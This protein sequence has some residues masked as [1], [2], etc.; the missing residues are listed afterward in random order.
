MTKFFRSLPLTLIGAAALTL[1]LANPAQAV[2]FS[3]IGDAPETVAGAQATGSIVESLTAISGTVVGATGNADIFRIFLS[4]GTLFSATTATAGTPV[5]FDTQLFL[6]TAAGVGL[7][8]N[9]DG[10]GAQ[11]P[12]ST[13]N[14]TPTV[15]GE[16]LLAISGFDYDP[17]AGSTNIFPGGAALP[18][19]S[20]PLTNWQLFPGDTEADAGAYTI[21]LTGAQTVPEPSSVLGLMALAGLGGGAMLQRKRKAKVNA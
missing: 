6:F 14:F 9:D 15:S 11:F 8:S 19:T 5:N 16:Y 12:R 20:S 18:F 3:E 1:S 2:T 7:F 4:A 10:P 13:L 17:Y 21:A